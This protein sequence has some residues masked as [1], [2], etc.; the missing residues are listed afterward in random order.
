ML[1][2]SQPGPHSLPPSRPDTRST[3]LSSADDTL[4]SFTSFKSDAVSIEEFSLSGITTIVTQ[5]N[6]DNSNSTL[7]GS[8][9]LKTSSPVS[10]MIKH[11]HAE[12]N[13]R[14]NGL[15]M[16]GS[17]SMNS[18]YEITTMA[19][20]STTTSSSSPRVCTV[21]ISC[22]TFSSS[23]H[24]PDSLSLSFLPQNYADLSPVTKRSIGRKN[25]IEEIIET[26]ESYISS[27]KMLSG[28]YLET[29][30]NKG[31]N[32]IPVKATHGYIEML[33][34]TH[35]EFLSNL[36]FLF[37]VPLYSSYQ[38]DDD[39]SPD[40]HTPS[41]PVTAAL[42]AELI[43]LRA[44][45]VFI[46]QEYNSTYDLVLKLMES[47]K[48]DPDIGLALTKSYQHFLESTQKEN[49]K[50]DLSFMSLIHK[51]IQRI[52]KYKLFLELLS[53]LT[54]FEE[55]VVCHQKIQDCIV[56]VD[57]SIMEVNR[58]GLQEKIKASI[59]FSG[60]MFGTTALRFPVEYLGPPLLS[61]A[62]LITWVESS[63]NYLT[64]LQLGVFLFK[65]HVIFAQVSKSTRFDVKFL[66]PLS[67]CKVVDSD[68]VGG[69][70]TCYHENS[71]KLVFEQSFKLYE[72]L[73]TAIDCNELEIWKERLEIFTKIVNGPYKFDYSSSRHHEEQGTFSSTIIPITMQSMD[74]KLDKIPNTT[75]RSRHLHHFYLFYDTCYFRKIIQI[76]IV[77][78]EETHGSINSVR[79]RPHKERKNVVILKAIERSTVENLLEEL[80]SDELVTTE[81]LNRRKKS[82]RTMRR[83][84]LLIHPSYPDSPE[85]IPVHS[86]RVQVQECSS[87][88]TINKRVSLMRRT[89][90]VVG[91]A[92]RSLFITPAFEDDHA[93]AEHLKQRLLATESA[94]DDCLR[95]L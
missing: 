18:L 72:V 51:P 12:P 53:K 52:P 33:I 29:L 57:Y 87:E 44:I 6:E 67:V 24:Y 34:S 48:D 76:N 45:P 1:S 82:A 21:Q 17:L 47:K 84:R 37:K 8:L 62:L 5:D 49:E 11:N 35:S 41:S 71:F 61:G 95:K 16:L 64:S 88:M 70:M 32:G 92:L 39:A 13:S 20:H 81:F 83:S 19:K 89:S 73:L 59:L 78:S 90:L 60:L 23:N 69:G 75:I 31:N 25:V 26:E 10:L 77:I 43:S 28:I 55:D 79:F 74:T 4:K 63:E 3:L 93:P 15:D 65:S 86:G 58:Y 14:D 42:V 9:N 94:K 80:W 85:V 66:I 27:L 30:I 40:F 91:D 56:R 7:A 68:D 38:A 2:L 46:Y 22:G 36:R 54:P 50:L